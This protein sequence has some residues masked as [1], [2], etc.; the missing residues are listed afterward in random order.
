MISKFLLT[1][2][3]TNSLCARSANAYDRSVGISSR[4]M[5][6]GRK[7]IHVIDA[8]PIKIKKLMS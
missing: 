1:H 3:H 5:E 4:S 8:L 7:E 6:S 2:E